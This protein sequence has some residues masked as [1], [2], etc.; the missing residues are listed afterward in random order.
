MFAAG[1]I[2]YVYF[3]YGKYHCLNIVTE[4]EDNPCA[5][6]IRGAEVVEGFEPA[7]I[8]RYKK[9]FEKITPLQVKNLSNGPGKLCQAFGIDLTLNKESL[10]NERIFIC[11]RIMGM[12]KEAKLIA[13][14]KRIGVTY[15]E[16][17]ADF[18]WRFY[19]TSN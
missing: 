15:A 1:G 17:A 14:G 19:E 3:V 9:S 11:D 8:N 12:E 18:L 5:V 10:Q 16:E 13:T 7:A 4:D 6:L 2:T